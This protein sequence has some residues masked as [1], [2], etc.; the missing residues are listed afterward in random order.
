MSLQFITDSDGETTGVFIPISE[1]NKLKDR[2]NDI[3]QSIDWY[4]DLTPT[5]K[6]EIE[7]ARSELDA[8]KGI[9]HEEVR[10]NIRQ[11]IE[12]KKTA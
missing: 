4:D 3:D 9:P 2:Y 5:Q 6:K 10:K 11:K 1:W 8:G 12:N 7:E